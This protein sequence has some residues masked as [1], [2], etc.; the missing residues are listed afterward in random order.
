MPDCIARDSRATST[1]LRARMTPTA[2]RASRSAAA[3]ARASLVTARG[4]MIT[5]L[6]FGSLS[7]SLAVAASVS[8]LRTSP[9]MPESTSPAVDA[10]SHSI[11]KVLSC[12]VGRRKQREVRQ[13]NLGIVDEFDPVSWTYS[14]S[15]IHCAGRQRLRHRVDRILYHRARRG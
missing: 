12:S 6:S 5:R 15:H 9:S 10:G 2:G 14:H 8:A 11:G 3:N 4:P 1:S 7:R 13:V